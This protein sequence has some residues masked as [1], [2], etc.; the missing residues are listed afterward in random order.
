MSEVCIRFCHKMVLRKKYQYSNVILYFKFQ[1][2]IKVHLNAIM[3]GQSIH[4]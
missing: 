3:A 4:K 1:D 2:H